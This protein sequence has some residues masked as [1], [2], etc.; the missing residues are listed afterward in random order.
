MY[1]LGCKHWLGVIARKNVL[2]EEI[3]G[4]KKGAR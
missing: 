4:L 1:H 3:D 2:P